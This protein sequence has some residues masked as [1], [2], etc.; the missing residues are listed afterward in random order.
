[1]TLRK[2]FNFN[3]DL[4]GYGGTEEEA[5]ENAIKKL[6]ERPGEPEGL[7]SWSATQTLE[8]GTKIEW[9]KVDGFGWSGEIAIRGAY[10]KL[11]GDRRF[12]TPEEG[13]RQKVF[14]VTCVRAILGAQELD[15]TLLEGLEYR[16]E[17]KTYFGLSLQDILTLRSRIQERSRTGKLITRK[18]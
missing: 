13:S 17:G 16:Q 1:M 9:E 4:E 12:N 10:F 14:N 18:P 11:K 7:T 2:R 15:P 8:D 3:V 6:A 5:W